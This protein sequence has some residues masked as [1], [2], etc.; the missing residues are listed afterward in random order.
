MILENIYV[1]LSPGS[2]SRN[3]ISSRFQNAS[4]NVLKSHGILNL[5]MALPRVE[6]CPRNKI[7]PRVSLEIRSLLGSKNAP[8]DILKNH[9]IMDLNAAHGSKNASDNVLK[10]H[11]IMDLSV[12]IS[13]AL[14][15][16]ECLEI[17]PRLKIYSKNVLDINAKIMA[18]EE[19]DV[20]P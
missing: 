12:M 10:N 1:W 16:E 20:E 13:A 7:S 4:D 17:S 5:S 15:R 14:L 11:G 9:G 2:A 3:K 19:K 18:F 6:E 8:D